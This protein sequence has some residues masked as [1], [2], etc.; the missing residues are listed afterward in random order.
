[1]RNKYE[2]DLI[3]ALDTESKPK[4]IFQWVQDLIVSDGGEILK[5][6]VIGNRRLSYEIEKRKEGYYGVIYYEAEPSILEE[7]ERQ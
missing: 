2:I 6:S 3:I 1:M 7:L 4:D 5:T